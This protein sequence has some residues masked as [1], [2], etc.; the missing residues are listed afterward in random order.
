MISYHDDA[1]KAEKKK[2]NHDE[3]RKETQAYP[4]VASYNV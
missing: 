1:K 4:R 2:E 3:G